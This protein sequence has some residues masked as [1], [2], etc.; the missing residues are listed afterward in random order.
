[1]NKQLSILLFLMLTTIMFSQNG[2][3]KGIITNNNNNPLYDVN[4]ILK[5]TTKGTLSNKK[6]YFQIQNLQDGTYVLSISNL[7]Y[8]T[9]EIKVSISNNSA[10]DLETIKLYE[11]NEILNEIVIESERTNKFSRKQSAYVAKMPLKNIENSQVYSTITNQLLVSQSANNFEDA[12]KNAVGVDKLW[13]STGRSGDGAGY[14]SIRGFSVQPQLVN[15]VS[16]ITNGFINPSN[17]ERVE[18]IKGPSATLF[19]ST[20]TSYGGLIN[21]VTKK[22]YNSFGGSVTVAGGSFGFRKVN[23][24]INLSNKENLSFR[25]NTGYQEEDSFQDNGYKKSVFIAPSLTYKVNNN[26]TFN[27]SYEASENEQTNQTFLFLNRSAPL[28][29]NTID[30]LNYDSNKSLTN[31]GVIIENPTQNFRGEIA[32][33]LSDNWSSQT[34][35]AGG[36]AKSNGFYTYLWNSADWT[37]VS[38]PAG[39]PNFA[40][41]AQETDAKTKTLNLQQNFIGEFKLGDLQNKL[42]VGF[43]YL[44]TTIIDK[45]SNWGYL[46]SINI[47]GDLIY[48]E[49]E[50]SAANLNTVLDGIGNS[51]IETKQNVFGA[52]ASN[53]IKLTSKLSAMASIRF[54]RFEYEGDVN[55]PSDDLQVYDES[56]WSPKF[57]VVYQPILNKFAIFGNYQN[58]FSY[59]NPELVPA[60]LSNPSAGTVLQSYDLERANQLEFGV[61]TNLFNNKLEATLNYYNIEVKDKIMGYGASKQQDATV[62]SNGIEL[63][64]NASPT[65]GLNLRGGF[66]YNNAEVTK[67]ASRPDLVGLRPAES[68]SDVIYNFWGDYKITQGFAKNVGFG[69]GF[70]GASSYNTMSDYTNS[71]G[72]ELPAYTVFN[73]SIYYETNKY[74]ISLKGN[75][76]SDKEYYSGWS[77][78]T[79]QQKRA[80]IATLNYKF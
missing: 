55:D 65:K 62:N 17:V 40:L 37:D 18:V 57:G 11:G 78:V 64:L 25:L 15:G 77:T 48:G 14:Y 6:G 13:S 72:F 80:F 27:L 21:I 44:K 47:Q 3:V 16:G 2:S 69:A 56:T 39:T 8:K 22:P 24:D 29:F 41:Y 61:K 45:S 12:L 66:S 50:I 43:D 19:G 59:V 38:N 26:L 63:E 33:K 70:N 54:D 67:S 71:G 7:G 35:I 68:G 28:V 36:T 60:D 31:D 76:L 73:A 53:V 52:Y 5:T 9:R 42:L 30:E 58:S 51:N 4:I 23:A 20:L 10:I 74:R 46:H 32:Y 75:N 34:I 49:P 79:P 1:M